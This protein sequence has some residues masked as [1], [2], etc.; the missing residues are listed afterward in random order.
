MDVPAIVTPAVRKGC[1]DSLAPTANEKRYQGVSQTKE[2]YLKVR[3]VEDAVE[4]AVTRH[5]RAKYATAC[6]RLLENKDTIQQRKH[7]PRKGPIRHDTKE[8]LQ[9]HPDNEPAEEELELEGN[10]LLESSV[11][12]QGALQ[13]VREDVYQE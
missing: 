9:T 11:V 2:Y 10:D 6:S 13:A 3:G 12:L 5:F 4:Q 7:R 8:A 1:R